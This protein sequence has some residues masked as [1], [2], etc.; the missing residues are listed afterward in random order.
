VRRVVLELGHEDWFALWEIAR[1]VQQLLG[2]QEAEAR[3]LAADACASL[4]GAGLVQ[5][6]AL[7]R[8]SEAEAIEVSGAL[9]VLKDD[10]AWEQVGFPTA[11]EVTT[12]PKG[13]AELEGIWE[14][15]RV[16]GRRRPHT[17]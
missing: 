15:E 14:K 8:T 9:V 3:K 7:P 5:M 2:V 11:H 16:S 17:I 12:T 1:R 4:L 10:G 13:D 6:G